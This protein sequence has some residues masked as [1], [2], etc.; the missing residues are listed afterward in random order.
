MFTKV[1]TKRIISLEWKRLNQNAI[2]KV[3]GQNCFQKLFLNL[4]AAIMAMIVW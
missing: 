1:I 2:D 3:P 4:S